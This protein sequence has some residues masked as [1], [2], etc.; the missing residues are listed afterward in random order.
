[1]SEQLR[2]A[3]KSLWP[4]LIVLGIY[5]LLV[6][7]FS[8]M[9][10]PFEGP[11]EPQHYAYI[12]WLVE[13]NDFPPQGRA[14]WDTPV[15]QESSQ[16]PLYYLLASIP[17]RLVGVTNPRAEYRPNPHPFL[18]FPLLYPDNDN[19]AIHYPQDA[20]PLAGGWLALYLSRGVTASFGVLL[21]VS[22]YGLARQAVPG[23]RQVAWLSA[24]LVATIPQVIYLSGLVSNDIPVAATSTMLLWMV[25]ALIRK[26]DS[27]WLAVGIGIAAGLSVLLKASALLMAIPV[28][29][30]LLWLGFSRQQAWL[31]IAR[32]TFLVAIGA[33]LTAGWWYVRS[34]IM[35]GSP[36]GLETHDQAPWAIIDPLLLG[37]LGFRWIEVFRSFWL[38]FGW[39]TIKPRDEY[40]TIFLLLVFIA[41]I[42]LAITIYRRWKS[43]RPRIDNTAAIFLIL[44][45]T[46]LVV[47]IF[48]EIWM[49]RVLAPYGRLMY[50]AIGAVALFLIIGWRA[51]HP[52]LPLIP[53]AITLMTSILSPFLLIKPAYALPQF[54][55]GEEIAAISST[56]WFFGQT[57][58]QPIAELLSVTALEQ[59][60][61]P[62]AL[63]P[64]EL[65][66]RAIAVPE[67][68]YTM[69][70]HLIGPENALVSS[71]RT[72]PG[73][74][75][76]P[77]PIWQ[78]GSAWC[79]LLHLL[80]LEED[81]PGTL[82]YKIEVGMVDPESGERLPLF[83]A[84]GQEIGAAF[85]G[86]VLVDLSADDD[87]Q[88]NASGESL[89]LLDYALEPNWRPGEIKQLALTW[90]VSTPLATDYQVYVH[91]REAISGETV[92]QADGPP[93]DGWYPTSRWVPATRITDQR[94]FSLPADL[95]P[96]QYDLFVGFYDLASGERFGREYAL[97]TVE[98]QP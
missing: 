35:F 2:K 83:D 81:V 27:K 37:E 63:L 1:M 92:A 75:R 60:I 51:I 33:L 61:S 16:P 69:L 46:L 89:A 9:T 49:R 39:G 29:L 32:S 54:L 80:V 42:G 62:D 79:D 74:G 96:G 43:P 3:L 59:T 30:A 25:A 26:G 73:L 95:A 6:T 64:V 57:P 14:S 87:A 98:I 18:G 36:L 52:K 90:A 15:Q 47:A 8:W 94:V 68:D 65:C 22:V 58:D 53:L 78:P 21:I 38:F 17:A 24:F 56:N 4:L 23:Q 71:R 34:W 13:H 85:A 88:S 31:K 97:E 5:L 91:L 67:Q 7:L 40:Y 20:S 41:L 28:G 45:T 93:L 48:L 12:E 76:Y 50:P 11:D 10:P 19:R 44:F 84:A 55:T 72:I 82:V 86:D 70:V 66:W 77:T